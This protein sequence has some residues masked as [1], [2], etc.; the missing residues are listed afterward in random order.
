MLELLWYATLYLARPLD[1][2]P[3]ALA[4]RRS[5]DEEGGAGPGRAGLGDEDGVEDAA[6]GM[7]GPEDA[8]GLSAHH[9]LAD[10]RWWI[11]GG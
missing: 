8:S 7:Q 11:G 1:R 5:R 10:W 6:L 9:I 4:S 3:L 2:P